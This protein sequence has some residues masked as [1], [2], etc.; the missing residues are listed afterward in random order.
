MFAD[1]R[2]IFGFEVLLFLQ[3]ARQIQLVF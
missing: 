3:T 1:Q 2:A